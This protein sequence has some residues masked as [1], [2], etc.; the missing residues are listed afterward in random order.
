MRVN[1]DSNLVGLRFGDLVIYIYMFKEL[2]VYNYIYNSQ[3]KNIP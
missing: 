2:Q 3:F 1:Y